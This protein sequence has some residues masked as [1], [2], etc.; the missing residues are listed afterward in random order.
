MMKLNFSSKKYKDKAL[1]LARKNIPYMLNH[2]D[3]EA[4]LM[5]I[6][7]LRYEDLNN[8]CKLLSSKFMSPDLTPSKCYELLQKADIALF[9]EILIPTAYE[10]LEQYKTLGSGKTPDGKFISSSWLSHSLYEAEVARTL[11]KISNLDESISFQ[12]GLLH[13]IG[14]KKTHD[15]SHTIKGFEILIDEGWE[16]EAIWCLTHSFL[17]D[18]TSGNHKGGRYANCDPAEDGFYVDEKLVAHPEKVIEQDDLTEFLSIFNYT[19]YD[20][21]LNISDLMATDRGITN[22]LKRVEDIA[23]RKTPDQRNRNYFINN[24]TNVLRFYLESTGQLKDI[25]ISIIQNEEEAYQ[26]FQ[27]I[28]GDFYKFYIESLRKNKKKKFII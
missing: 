27:I 9:T 17:M 11:A 7:D 8:Y 1:Q 5:C 2:T 16:Q 23:T 28:S 13:D 24:F 25:D 26:Y 12:M 3:E 20:M 18:F 6:K 10:C 22:P 21:I 15:F 4:F 19:M 14:R